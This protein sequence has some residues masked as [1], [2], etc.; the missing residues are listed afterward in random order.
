MH[1]VGIAQDI[2]SIATKNASKEKATRITTIRV[3]VG[4]LSGIVPDAL[5][6]AFEVISR[7][8]LAEDAKLDIVQTPIIFWCRNCK[9]EFKTR[10]FDY[11]CPV[12]GGGDIELRGGSEFKIESIEVI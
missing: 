5:T 4:P 12:C 7:G 11:S 6:F 1:E 9:I 3:L 8:S 10:E 2:L